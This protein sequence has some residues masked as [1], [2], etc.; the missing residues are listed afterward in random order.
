MEAE[1]KT[2]QVGINYEWVTVPSSKGRTETVKEPLPYDKVMENLMALTNG[3]MARVDTLVFVKPDEAGGQIHY[4]DNA[5]DAFSYLGVRNRCSIDWCTS[6]TMMSKPEAYSALAR[7]LPSF[8]GIETAPHYP[9]MKDLYYN[10]P[11]LPDPNYD[12]LDKLLDQFCPETPEDRG[13]ILSLFLT[14]VWGGAVGQRPVYV[15]ISPD[16]RGVGKSTVAEMVAYLL[17]QPHIAGS[18][19][20]PMSDLVTRLLS[21][22]GLASRVVVFDNEEGR[23]ANAEFAGLITSPIVSGRRLYSGEGRRPNNLLW[24]ITLNTPTLDSDLAS[25]A[26]PIS[27]R[28][29]TYSPDWKSETTTLIDSKRWAI[30]AALVELLKTPTTTIN[31]CTRW[32]AWENEVLAK[33]VKCCPDVPKVQNL[34]KD[35]QKS[36]DDES[37]EIDLIR[38]G[39]R[40][41]IVANKYNLD[42]GSYFFSNAIAAD[43]C[44]KVLGTNGR[45]NTALR[46]LKYMCGSQLPELKMYRHAQWG[47]GILWTGRSDLFDMRRILDISAD[48]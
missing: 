29:P 19:K 4:M 34:I 2:D 35:R 9:E 11:T 23:V 42:E 14:S 45:R 21:P 24:V 15:I 28:R 8:K 30:I 37:D 46:E 48:D 38:D 25:R 17:N 40:E 36:F 3:T 13:L 31:T 12:A 32:G 44:N 47:R 39:F 5:V 22:T 6:S 41:K 10:H 1:N 33:I 7:M 27:V 16:G 20:N 18:T 26:I 43:I